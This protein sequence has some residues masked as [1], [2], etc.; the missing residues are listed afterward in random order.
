MIRIYYKNGNA[1][2]KDTNIRHLSTLD[3]IIWVDM[4]SPLQEEEEFVETTCG[5]SIQTPQEIAEIESSSRYFERN[6]EITANSNFLKMEDGKFNKYPVSFIIKNT[7]LYT[8]R[9]TDLSSFADVVRKIKAN[10]EIFNSGFD[11]MMSIQETRI[12]VDADMIER[13]S[14]E[15]SDFS[16]TL[17]TEQNPSRELLLDVTVLQEN[18]MMLR[19][20][21]ID[22]QRVLSY[23]LKSYN[24]AEDKKE[25]LRIVLKDITSLIEYSAF[26]FERLEYLQET[27]TGLINL[28]QN[29]IMKRFTV[30]S[31]AFLPPTLISGIFGMNFLVIP[32]ADAKLGFLFSLLLMMAASGSVLFFFKRKGW[33]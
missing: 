1:V 23:L 27:I 12:D 17:N 4:Q 9:Q 3:N 32:M 21:I 31:I 6:N 2:M 33:I 28:E 16:K 26:N 15:I 14:H 25:R 11:V 20:S 7:I 29:R 19:E 18:T 5:I 24:F 8:Y 13:V 22:K 10:N 30:F